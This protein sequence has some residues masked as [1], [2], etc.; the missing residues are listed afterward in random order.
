MRLRPTFVGSSFALIAACSA[1]GE[2]PGSA[3]DP[4]GPRARAADLGV[5]I[6]RLLSG[7]LR[8][9]TDVPGV[10]VGHALSLI[11]I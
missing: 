9:I 7:P 10:R 5:S 4:Q 11:H 6:G 2:A 3:Q 1:P 8:A